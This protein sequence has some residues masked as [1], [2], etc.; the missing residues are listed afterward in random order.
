MHSGVKGGPKKMSRFFRSIY[1]ANFRRRFLGNGLS[2]LHKNY[3]V[4]GPHL[5][6]K[7]VK[8]LGKSDKPFPRNRRR[9]LAE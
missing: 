1:S 6:A 3:T 4:L 7:S 8:F 2:D 5:C 9:K